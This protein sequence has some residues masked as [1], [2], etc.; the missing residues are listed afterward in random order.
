MPRLTRRPVA[1]LTYTTTCRFVSTTKPTWS[2]T[3]SPST[4][5]SATTWHFATPVQTPVAGLA[6]VAV[7][8]L[9]ALPHPTSDSVSSPLTAAPQNRPRME[10]PT[11]V[12]GSSSR[13][14]AALLRRAQEYAGPP[15][16]GG[17][18]RSADRSERHV[19]PQGRPGRVRPQLD[20]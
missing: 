14:T 13:P 7:W 6:G 10:T 19:H 2:A 17:A 16:G 15:A 1:V 9:A 5:V 11:F 3:P 12:G 4:S 18:F 8:L 20:Q